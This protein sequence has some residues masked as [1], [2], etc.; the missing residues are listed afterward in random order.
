MNDQHCAYKYFYSK[1]FISRQ[2]EFIVDTCQESSSFDEF[3][4]KIKPYFNVIDEKKIKELY[5]DKK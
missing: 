5:W 3:V 4:S 1:P 2:E